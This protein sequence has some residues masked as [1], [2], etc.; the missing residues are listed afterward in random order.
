MPTLEWIGKDKVVNHHQDV[1]FRV[2]E[3]RYTYNQ[4]SKTETEVSDGNMII[5]GD[6]LEALKALLPKYEGKIKC[7]Y[8][9][10]PYNTGNE[11]WIYN[12]NVND[13]KILKWLGK[14]VGSQGEDL[15]RHDKWLCMMYPRLRLLQRLLSNDGAIFISIDDNEQANLKLICDEIF[16][17]N[18]FITDLIWRSADSSNND[19]K[20]FSVDY[21]HTVIYSKIPGWQ[22]LRFA[23]REENNQHYKNPDNDPR[24]PWFQSNL[25]SPNYR[26]NLQYDVI[27]PNGNIIKSPKNG[28]R[29]SQEKMNEWIAD[30]TVIFPGDQTRIIK[31]TFLKD[32]AGIVPSN[33]WWDVEDTGHNRNA[34][35]EL[36]KLFPEL[37]SS[38]VFKTPKPTKFIEKILQMF[39]SENLI[40][41]DSFAGSGTTAHAVLNMNKDGGNRKFILVEMEDYAEN[42][43]AERVRRVINGYADVP[44][45]GDSFSFYELGEPLMFGDGNINENIPIEKIRD[46]VWYMEIK[47]PVQVVNLEENRYYLGTTG[48]AAYFFN[49]E[50]DRMTTLDTGFLSKIRIHAERYIIYADQC[51]LSDDD[52]KRYNIT[53]KKIPRDIAKL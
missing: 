39:S 2:L 33:I 53:F 13:P 7:I 6:N 29:W 18:C 25:Q 36:L 40:V 16:G 12:D 21:N 15:S 41:L 24:G 26:A 3:H 27:A 47:Q 8:I 30:G 22:P 31:K 51:T 14:V 44:G 19:S 1:P 50:K 10:P 4:G 32:Q 34:K 35:Y 46:Y 23:R 28:W 20:Q 42:I 49:Y 52:L 43:T 9:D 17:A 5:K 45:T 11:G 38:E 37:H 48:G